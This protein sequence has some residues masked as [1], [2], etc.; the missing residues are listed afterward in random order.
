MLNQSNSSDVALAANQ[1][2]KE[3]E[4]WLKKLSG[5][6][7]KSLFPY[8]NSRSI[9][10]QLQKQERKTGTE[11]IGFP[12][13][14]I[15][16]LLWVSNESDVRLLMLLAG[17]LVL[18]LNKYTGIED[19]IFGMPIY[20]Q[21]REGDFI[22]TVLVFRNL[23]RGN[24]TFKELLYQV[25]QTLDEAVMH[26][27]YP[28]KSLLYE[29]NLAY[30]EEDFPLF[31]AV[32]VLENIQ[33]KTFIRHIHTNMSFLFSRKDEYIEGTIE[34]SPL[35]YEQ[36]TIK[37]LA[38][39]FK[40][41]LEAA[42]LDVNLKI[43][44]LE[45]LSEVEK[46]ELL[47]DFNDTRMD[48]SRDKTVHRLFEEQVEKIPDTTA[49]ECDNTRLTYLELNKEA[50][51]L[52]HSLRNQGV[53]SDT[54]VGIM[55][56]RS[57]GMMVGLLGIL[58]AGGAYLPIDLDY[59]EERTRYMLTDSRVDI[60]LTEKELAARP[61]EE[62]HN[63]GNT[64]GP[65]NLLYV[66]YT[67]GSTGRPKGTLVA[68][69]GFVNLAYYHWRVFGRGKGE[70][71]SQVASPGFDAMGFEIWPC[72]AGGSTLCI[73]D[74]ETRADSLKLKKWLID[75]KIT[76]SFQATVMAER[77]LG[78]EW[79]REGVSLKAL[80]AAGDR[81][82]HYP[83]PG[84]PFRFYNLYGPTEDTVWTTWTYVGPSTG[85]P[86]APSIGRP[87]ANHRVYIVGSHFQLQPVGVFGELC[88]AGHGLSE[89][90]LNSPRLM[91]EK[92]VGNPFVP[93]EIMYRTGDLARW[94][95]DGNIEFLGRKDHQVKIRGFRIELGEIENQLLQHPALKEV[96]VIAIKAEGED[97][98]APGEVKEG[99]THLCAY[100]VFK[101]NANA[102]FA[103]LRQCLFH[104]LPHY[105]IPSYFVPLECLPLSPNG[106][107]DRKRLPTPETLVS[108]LDYVSP[109]DEVEEKLV[110]IWRD[111]L[112]VEKEEPIGI[113]SDF[114]E[115]GGHSLKATILSNRIHKEL[116]VKIPMI[117]FFR[118]PNIR[119]ISQYIKR[120]SVD[121]YAS[122]ELA[123]Q[124]DY[125][126]LSSSQARLYLLQ[127]LDLSSTAYNVLTFMELEGPLDREKLEESFRQLIR[128]HESLRTSLEI[129]DERPVQ[130]IHEEV[131]F[132]IVY[133]CVECW[134]NAG[135]ATS[136]IRLESILKDF[137]RPFDLSRAPLIRVG[138]IKV[139]ESV[140]I[141][142]V[143]MHHIITDGI[144][145]KLLIENFISLYT[146]NQLPPLRLQY[147]D[148]SEWQQSPG[149]KEAFKQQEAFWLREFQEEIP[150]LNMPTDFNR[151]AVQ[152][153]EGSTH[154]FDLDDHETSRLNQL[155]RQE[156]ATLFMVLLAAY[157][158]LLFKISGQETIVVGTPVAGRRHA[159]LEQ[160]IGV[161]INMLPLKSYPGEADTFS[162]FFQ[163]LKKRTLSAFENQ[164]YPYEELVE[165]VVL[166]RNMSRNPL[167]DT[168]FVLQNMF[169]AS[170]MLPEQEI[171]DLKIR[172]Y[173]FERK[174]SQFDLTLTTIE[175]GNQL[176]F[177]FEYC[178]R[179]FKRETVEKFIN[180][181]KAVISQIIGNPS[182]KISRVE[183]ITE[184]EKNWIL[185]EF[186]R[187]DANY[188]RNKT[189]HQLFEE[190]VEKTPENI[191]LSFDDTHLK[192]K[193]LNDRANWLASHLENSGVKPDTIVAL[194]V[195]PSIEMIM[196]MIG[197][198]KA[199][200]AYL[201]I[202]PDYPE[203]RVTYMLADS[204]AKI[205]LTTRDLSV[206]IT[207]KKEII[208]LEND[209]KLRASRSV[210]HGGP[211]NLA[212]IIYTS[213]T[214]GKPKG[215][216]IE[217]RNVV[218]L[219]FNDKN[220]FDFT[221]DD[222]WTM[223][224]S[225]CF[226]FSVWEMYGA[227]LYGGKLIVIPKMTSRNPEEYLKLLQREGVTILNQTPP[228]FYNLLS[229]EL[230]H[231]EKKL[232]LRYVI[233]GGEALAP[234]G[235]K[236]WKKRYPRTK[237]I[238]MYGITETTV[239]VT[240]KE[241]E[242]KEIQENRSNI[243]SP[244]PTLTTFVMDKH[245]NLLP[246]G[247]PGEVY[248]GGEGVSRGYMSR[249]ELTR[250]KF[251]K[252]PQKA[253]EILYRTGDLAKLNT[254]GDMEY[255]GR[256]D[257]QVKLRGFRIELGEIESHLLK[258]EDINEA[259]VLLQ[260]H[261]IIAYIAAER[262]FNSSQ[263]KEYL[264]KELPR[265]MIPSYFEQVERI[266]LTPTGK[267]DRRA[268]KSSQKR[269]STDVEYA[270]PETEMEKTIAGIW[271]ETLN[272]DK[273][274]MHDNFFDLGGNSLNIVKVYNK[275]K[276]ITGTD[277][278]LVDMFQ[279]PTIHSLSRY[280]ASD[281]SGPAFSDERIQDT[282][283]MMEEAME[284][285][286][287]DD[288]E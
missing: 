199:G 96:A 17:G 94:L 275:L 45:M 110:E 37:R 116:K 265:Y 59:P 279:Y 261:Y 151:P 114:F 217:H 250:E 249:S 162:H 57:I 203:N 165:K 184:E 238:N 274:G 270:A 28:L 123:A 54:I 66:I 178:T 174:T 171:A 125:Y 145:H 244:I 255:L 231:K 185:C 148:Y 41:L 65:E 74:N 278:P 22:N 243:G 276:T 220:L 273:V 192:Y 207:F 232:V 64:S 88:I 286:M 188:P 82:I 104:T 43:S 158:L 282:V 112:D 127:Q 13:P 30:S 1:S 93:G 16:R 42:L 208:Y 102:S 242:E 31:D 277:I 205:L 69:R 221:A 252:N 106:K 48:Y 68:H 111:V 79:P 196:G 9:D 159:D 256:I 257:H 283:D 228:A 154:H 284:M 25:K 214:T 239:H 157:N 6:L 120:S 90:Y 224:H 75:H 187:T 46:K 223:F 89:G 80:R 72:V 10:P 36:L 240:F 287:E 186:N 237:L 177:T 198:L 7:T 21:D 247:I 206:R 201:P 61:S 236:E 180:Y 77:L 268:L 285:L 258:H 164:D 195:A 225:Y 209:R 248:V 26:Q 267:V 60:L 58:K 107:V 143:D 281:Q 86:K 167:F 176:S 142:V 115:M 245:L 27:N 71:I 200:S 100:T 230:K 254:S 202:D 92:F 193:E 263:L 233:F 191:A 103:D 134:D 117:E 160:I 150:L 99:Y 33:D 266:P 52:A 23:I 98:S 197:I 189:I 76:I 149:V 141:L 19:I 8:D 175:M 126:A 3:R 140:H 119:G 63:S 260:D 172:P 56:E 136:S 113:D 70:R 271:L 280:L 84:T 18:L 173:A 288:N 169:E 163:D 129:I 2:V 20:K 210:L 222:V 12:P 95:P 219:L 51:R 15:S 108:H 53:K 204:N 227:L 122:I 40:N 34:Y 259:V 121:I 190:Q 29:L 132:E 155:A 251:I 269:L 215:V 85:N 83:S 24:M 35:H 264:A 211:K 87:I 97:G 253:G 105:M 229:E 38:G 128:R 179:L 166:E 183:I 81:L 234:G 216:M 11:D 133:H 137:V 73:V 146:G 4:Y 168:V 118:A 5:N 131:D 170:Q 156:E 218:R 241:I 213:G 226:D 49:V 139:E 44:N 262:E 194:M 135:D 78:E 55:V 101:E 32:V 144:S 67:S 212:Y 91:A 152:S 272:L 39:H 47:F 181:F 182:K 153:S 109:R 235:L 161:F 130:K 147:K 50:N 62:I 124:K 138:L 14:L 246:I